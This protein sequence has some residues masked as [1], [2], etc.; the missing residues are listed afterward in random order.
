MPRTR[1]CPVGVLGLGAIGSDVAAKFRA[2]GF[3][4]RGWSRTH[5]SLAGVECFAGSAGPRPFL[6]GCR[7]LVCVLPLTLETRGLLDGATLA[8]LPRGAY[9]VNIARGAVVVEEDLL[10]L[11]DS[12]HLAGAALDVFRAEPLPDDSRFW[13]HPNVVVTPHIA[14]ITDAEACVHQVAEA[15]RR[16]RAGQPLANLV[17]RARGY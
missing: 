7:A 13:T 4:V 9:F 11:L 15:V 16:A 17:D 6:A 1:D 5:R 8:A 10:G 3:P 2:L 14:A 12:G